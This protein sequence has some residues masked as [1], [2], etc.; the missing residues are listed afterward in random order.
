MARYCV[1]SLAAGGYDR[2]F[3]RNIDSHRAYAAK[4]GYD[5]HCLVADH[6]P[7]L[8]REVAWLKVPLLL[9][10]LAG[11]YEGV[12]FLDTD[13]R[14][15]EDCPPFDAAVLG[16]EG[17][18]F[19]AN[20]HSGRINSGVIILRNTPS[21]AALLRRILASVGEALPAS[22]SVGWGENGYFIQYAPSHPGFRLLPEAWNNT[23]AIDRPTH[24]HHFTGPLRD[25]Y[26]FDDEEALAWAE[27]QKRAKAKGEG[28]LPDRFAFFLAI[29]RIHDQVVAGVHGLAPFDFAWCGLAAAARPGLVRRRVHVCFDVN[30][31]DPDNP[32]VAELVRG[33]RAT[34]PDVEVQIGV[35]PFWTQDYSQVD[36]L[37]IQWAEVLCAWK[38]PSE[39]LLESIAARLRDI[40]RTTRIVFTVH[41]I[42]LK[43]DF[44]EMAERLLD[45]VG[46]VASIFVHLSRASVDVFTERYARYPWARDRAHLVIG[47]GD[48]DI[49]RRLAPEPFVPALPRPTRSVLVFGGIRSAEELALTL[50]VAER[51][52]AQG[53]TFTI[54][55]PVADSLVH[56]KEQKRLEALGDQPIRRIH[57]RIP[58]RHVVSLMEMTDVVFL[59]RAGRLNSGVLF[60]GYTFLKPVVAP[61]S[62]SMAEAQAAVDGPVYAEGDA[63]DAARVIAEVFAAP[64][65]ERLALA[66]RTFRFKH[67]EMNWAQIGR[68]H[69]RAYEWALAAAP[70]RPRLG[71]VSSSEAA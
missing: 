23:T 45:A 47:H 39:D 36:V 54:A 4:H 57:R 7:A 55:G 19:L 38:R 52:A 50:D 60:L 49:Y 68:Q 20:G 58:S 30:E 3:R 63:A 44:G 12:L 22:A 66:S 5:Y 9:G 16:G 14:F 56:W 10:A 33:I 51:C 40:A 71:A 26:P 25:A 70:Q 62:H 43:A 29:A 31:A 35:A 28:G 42:D 53:I 34:T 65:V 15:T 41:N 48:Y 1:L 46:Q 27:I 21:A 8:A 24:I 11:G 18:V 32:Y 17:D 69:V 37:H 61:R 13:A 6:D 67:G 2:A 64:A 59:P